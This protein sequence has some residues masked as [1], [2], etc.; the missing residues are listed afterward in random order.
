MVAIIAF[1][2]GRIDPKVKAQNAKYEKS[3]KDNARDKSQSPTKKEVIEQF[4]IKD[5]SLCH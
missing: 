2:W 1:I 3:L 5:K 4:K